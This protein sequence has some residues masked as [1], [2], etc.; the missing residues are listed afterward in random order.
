MRIE[1]YSRLI[2]RLCR[3]RINS[4]TDLAR[5]V[6]LA[7]T[8]LVSGG[9][10]RWAAELRSAAS[11]DYQHWIKLYDTMTEAD[12]DALRRRIQLLTCR[13]RFRSSC[14]STIRQ[15]SFC[16]E[17]SNS[18]VREQIYDRLREAVHRRRP[19][20]AGHVPKVL[21]YYAKLD[22]RIRVC[23]RTT[24]GHIA[25]ASNSALAIAKGEF[26]AL[27]D[28]DDDIPPHAL[29]L[30]AEAIVAQP[31]VDLIFSDEDKLDAQGHRFGP[32]FKSD[33]NPALM[34]SQNMFSHLG[35]YRLS[36]VKKIGGFRLGFEGSQDYDLVLR[37]SRETA[38]ERIHHIP[39]ILYHW[40][41]IE[42]S[43]ATDIGMKPY[44]WDAGRRAIEEHLTQ[45]NVHE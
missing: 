22:P 32:Y 21:D 43:T 8:A 28:H 42:S 36:L 6:K 29:A 5:G 18:S 41:A 23:F 1:Y 26:V 14:P 17:Q 27:L 44:A 34:L 9:P 39:K 7:L 4:P 20:A 45:Q 31:D 35:V 24:N 19:L 30:V 25:E 10:R 37:C 11:P 12:K 3:Y 40:R 33:W 13:P 2:A 38:P 15:K 16:E